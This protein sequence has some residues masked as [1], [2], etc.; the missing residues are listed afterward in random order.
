MKNVSLDIEGVIEQKFAT[1]YLVCTRIRWNSDK[2]R[3]HSLKQSFIVA[4]LLHGGYVNS[5]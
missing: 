5:Q 1:I 3:T 2:N 4:F